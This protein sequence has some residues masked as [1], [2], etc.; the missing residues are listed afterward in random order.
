MH[1]EIRLDGD[2]SKDF[3]SQFIEDGDGRDE[4]SRLTIA[5]VTRKF[6]SDGELDVARFQCQDLVEQRRFLDDGQTADGDPPDEALLGRMTL[7]LAIKQFT[8]RFPNARLA[9]DNFI[10][11]YITYGSA[12]IDLLIAEF[13]PYE[14]KFNIFIEK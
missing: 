2:H 4:P 14:K 12:F 1:G 5:V 3:A 11:E 10:P 6:W 8:A 13:D 7:T 9:D